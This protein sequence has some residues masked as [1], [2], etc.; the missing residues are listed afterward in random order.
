MLDLDIAEYEGIWTA[1][2]DWFVLTPKP[3]WSPF[4]GSASYEIFQKL[5][6]GYVLCYIP[7][8][9]APIVIDNMLEANTEIVPNNQIY[10][11][12]L[13][14]FELMWTHRRSEYVLY[15]AERKYYS[16][17]IIHHHITGTDIMPMKGKEQIYLEWIKKMLQA[18]VETL[19]TNPH[20]QAKP[21]QYNRLASIVYLS[22]LPIDEIFQSS[23]E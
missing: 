22:C 23:E 9:L 19:N 18:G 15:L 8:L 12:H 11:H 4:F 21:I 16:G 20:D 2:S 1:F 13:D 10:R 17:H 5:S 3:D 14:K 6:I 7:P